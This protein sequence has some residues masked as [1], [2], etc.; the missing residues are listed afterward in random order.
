MKKVYLLMLALICSVVGMAQSVTVTKL[1]DPTTTPESG[2]IYAIQCN[3]QHD[4]IT[5]WMYDAGAKPLATVTPA[6]GEGDIVPTTYLWKFEAT[7]NEAEYTAQNYSTSKYIS[8]DGTGNGGAVTMA[9]AAKPFVISADEAGY[10][11][12]LKNPAA[13]QWIDM[14]WNG[15]GVETW[16]GGVGGSRR[17][18]IYEVEIEVA[19]DLAAAIANLNA[20]YQDYSENHQVDWEQIGDAY[21]QYSQE[22]ANAYEAALA[23]AENV[24]DAGEECGL[25]VEEIEAAAQAIKD[26]WEAVIASRKPYSIAVAPG[27]YVIKSALDFTETVTTPEEEDPET[28][29]MVGGETI[30]L[31]KAKSI[32][33]EKGNAKWMTF[34]PKA[35]FLF[36]VEASEK[37]NLYKL[38]NMLHGLTFNPIKTSTA[39]TMAETDSLISFDWR[40]NDVLVYANETDEEPTKSVTAINIRLASQAERGSVYAHAGGHGGGAGK[41]GNIVGWSTDPTSGMGASDWYLEPVDEATALAWIETASPIKVI[42]AM[43]DSVNVIKDAFPAQKVI[44][45]D[46]STHMDAQKPLITDPTQFHSPMTT[47]D[48]QTGGDIEAVYPFLL[49]GNTTTYWHSRWEDGNRPNGADYLQVSAI[50]EESVAFVMTRRPVANDHVTS[51]SVWGYDSDNDEIAKEDGVKLAELEMPF[52]SNTEVITSAPFATQG[53]SVIRFYAES[54]TNNRGYWHCSEF[55]MYPATGGYYYGDETKTQAAV[56]AELIAALEATIAAW[57]EAGYTIENVADPNDAAFVAAY[58]AVVNAYAAWRAVYADPAPLRS[59][60]NDAVAFASMIVTGTNPGQWPEGMGAET[61]EAAKA[62]AEAY[63][64]TGA[65]TPETMA[66]EVEKMKAAKAAVIAAAIQIVPGKWYTIRFASEDEY[67]EYNWDK[68]GAVSDVHGDLYENYIAPANRTEYVEDGTT[69]YDYEYAEEIFKGQQL[70]FMK[71]ANDSHF[72]FVKVGDDMAMMHQS[73]W[74]VTSNGQLSD[75]PALFSSEAIGYGKSLIKIR[76]MNGDEI[77]TGGASPSYIHAQVANH[78]MVAWS[79]TAIDSRSALYIEEVDEQTLEACQEQVQP[80]QMKF[81]VSPVGVSYGSDVQLYT[82]DGF[83]KTADGVKVAFSTTDKAEAGKAALMIVAGEYPAEPTADTKIAVE[84]T[85]GNELA[86]VPDSTQALQGTYKYQWVAEAD[87]TH[88]V[89]IFENKMQ[90]ATGKD[91]TDCARDIAAYTGAIDLNLAQEIATAGKDLVIEI[92]GEVD[93]TAINEVVAK[94]LNANGKIYTI[95]GKYMGNGN[96]GTARNMGTGIYIINGVKIYVK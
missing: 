69:K 36:K 71:G 48:T 53:K 96:I 25:T 42:T 58:N 61:I 2:K 70:R 91:N 90:M 20:I 24:I 8:I 56:R 47:D 94:A 81:T 10:Y 87:T 66:A 23:Y 34:E 4:G 22:A 86:V 35:D 21:G 11:V 33:E 39:A 28:G 27:Y 72:T 3:A 60:I 93:I 29:E 6:V 78:L 15:T 84:L 13:D 92:T 38:T 37:T 62:A 41:N 7:G 45:E 9:A 64:M 12:A 63:D 74:F 52:T 19:S 89:T 59:A 57:D 46:N 17:M 67:E 85:L 16:S 31:H 65:Y 76:Q 82:F 30:T 1:G 88:M 44:A 18:L 49:D 43:I 5:T 95:D 75:V 55:Q 51:M 40:A 77:T 73:G 32:Y 14:G 50:D 54:T 83:E 68:S 26:A 80:G 79:A